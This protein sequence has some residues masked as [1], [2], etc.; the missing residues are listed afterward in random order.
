MSISLRILLI[1]GAIFAS[2]FIGNRIHKSKIL[3]GDAIFWVLL[4]L[5]L[6]IL[7]LFPGIAIFFSGLL[8]I[9]SPAN[10]VFMAIL[11]LLMAKMFAN[12]SEIS[13]LKHR[14]NELAQENALLEK[15]LRD[16]HG[17]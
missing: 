6:I 16:A 2:A 9:S 1:A 15:R 5:L 4:S 10:F 7:A 11:V 8:G 13:M 3:M 14:V 17:E 12:S